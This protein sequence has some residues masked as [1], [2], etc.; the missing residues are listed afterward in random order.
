MPASALHDIP[1]GK[2]LLDWFGYVPRFHDA[3]LLDIAF[4]GRG[5]GLMRIHTWNMTDKPDA[6]GDLIID[7]HV[8]VTLALEGISTIDCV[9]FDMMPG[10]ILNLDITSIDRGFRIEWSASYGV[11]GSISARQMRV[12]LDPGEPSELA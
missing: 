11:S 4:S 6:Q 10:I 3:E 8:V 1:G 9:G 7:K 2:S 12:A 5:S